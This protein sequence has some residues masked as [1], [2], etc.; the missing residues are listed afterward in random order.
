MNE[1]EKYMEKVKERLRNFDETLNEIKMKQKQWK[2]NSQE[3]N[4]N[5]IIEK[6]RKAGTK[7]NE[8]EQTDESTWETIKREFDELIEDIGNALRNAMSYFK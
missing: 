2:D 3:F 6:Q 7:L 4:I 1:K 5:D 8:I